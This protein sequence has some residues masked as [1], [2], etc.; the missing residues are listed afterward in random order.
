MK[1]NLGRRR[2]A[3]FCLMIFICSISLWG[4]KSN[5]NSSSAIV[6]NENKKAVFPIDITDDLGR[7]VTLKSEANKIVSLAPGNTEILFAMGL[8][9]RVVGNT[10]FCNFPEEAKH[11]AKV[12]GFK[13]PSLEKIIALQPDLVLATGIHQQMI[14]G[15]EAAGLKVLVFKV[16]TIE[17]IFKEME[18]VG[19]A[20]NVNNQA[21]ALINSLKDRINAVSEKVSKIPES[22]KATV[23]YELWAE[24]LM[25]VGNDT[26]VGKVINLSGGINIVQDSKEKYPQ[27][28]EEVII[29][30]NP[31]VMFISYGHGNNNTPNPE[32]I[33][34]RKGWGDLSF[35]KNNRIYEIESDLLTTPGPRIVDGLEKMAG[36]LYPELFK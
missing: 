30:K 35:V 12:G 21:N 2:A 18:L 17:D 10:T 31:L 36:Y 28:S 1:I 5:S 6:D 25:T 19:Q 16:Q 27:L 14:E 15:M 4:C 9:N 33:A 8:G 23:Y 13:D 29:A 24:P 34:A 3:L 26:L 32:K 11:C 7:V 20:A 22:Q